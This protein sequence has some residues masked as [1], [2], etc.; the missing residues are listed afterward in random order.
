MRRPVSQAN[1]YLMAFGVLQIWHTF[2]DNLISNFSRARA[3]PKKPVLRVGGDLR[4]AAFGVWV[5][6]WVRLMLCKIMQ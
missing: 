2:F 3:V 6:L 1:F 4:A 5:S